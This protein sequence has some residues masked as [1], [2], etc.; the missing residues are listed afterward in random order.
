MLDFTI[1][2]TGKGVLVEINF[3]HF[4]QILVKLELVGHLVITWI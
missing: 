2:G 1:A 4:P 3:F